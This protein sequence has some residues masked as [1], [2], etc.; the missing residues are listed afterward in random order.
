[1]ASSFPSWVRPP[2]YAASFASLS[3]CNRLV[4]LHRINTNYLGNLCLNSIFY[5]EP[6]SP[7]WAMFVFFWY[8]QWFIPSWPS[9]VLKFALRLQRHIPKRSFSFCEQGAGTQLGTRSQSRELQSSAVSL[10]LKL[11]SD[12]SARKKHRMIIY[13]EYEP[14]QSKKV[15]MVL[16]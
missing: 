9:V 14:W 4:P 8:A 1:M 6:V 16:K 2:Q 7:V 3:L 13:K 10:S 12:F 5:P 15:N 11:Q